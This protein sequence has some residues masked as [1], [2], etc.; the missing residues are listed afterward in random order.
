MWRFCYTVMLVMKAFMNEG[1]AN[2]LGENTNE[3]FVCCSCIMLIRSHHSQSK[4]K[5]E[6]LIE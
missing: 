5:I 2:R 4:N 3:V 6:Q 1:D